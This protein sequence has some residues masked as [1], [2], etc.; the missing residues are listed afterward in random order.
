MADL[1]VS[2]LVNH[3]GS[4]IRH[5]F[6]HKSQIVK[7]QKSRKDKSTLQTFRKMLN[8]P[9]QIPDPNDPKYQV[10]G[11]E[12]LYNKDYFSAHIEV[13]AYA[14]EAA[15]VLLQKFGKEA[16]LDILRK[17]INF[18]DPNLPTAL[19]NYTKNLVGKRV[20][21]ELKKKIYTQ[22]INLSDRGVITE[23]HDYIHLVL[24]GYV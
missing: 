4:T 19:T 23:L 8:D 6:I 24:A 18:D 5:E 3:I 15:E 9:K 12:E 17:P 22:I 13:D 21:N 14:Y 10:P 16:A 2:A 7:Q 1:N 20:H 11:G